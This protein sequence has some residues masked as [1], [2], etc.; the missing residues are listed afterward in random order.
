MIEELAANYGLVGT[1]LGLTI[2]A[3]I[4]MVKRDDKR[5]A[6]QNTLVE[7]NT[8]ALTKFVEMTKKCQVKR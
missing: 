6:R 5:E 7:N 4:Y 8:V 3:L 2:T 1:M